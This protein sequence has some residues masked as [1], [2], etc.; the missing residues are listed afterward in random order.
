MHIPTVTVDQIPAPL[1]EGVFLLDVREPVEWASGRVEGAVHVPMNEI[2]DRIE[3]LPRD[4]RVLVIC[5]VG[6]RSAQVTGFLVHHGFDAV[7]VE[8]GMLEWA[9]AGKPMVGEVY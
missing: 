6:G 8:G 7:N 5:K 4:E 3:E 2:P 1:P 9:A